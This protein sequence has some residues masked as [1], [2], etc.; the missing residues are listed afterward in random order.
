M[1]SPTVMR[2]AKRT[3]QGKPAAQ[4]SWLRRVQRELKRNHFAYIVMIPVL[5]HFVLFEFDDDVAINALAVGVI[6]RVK[7]QAFDSG[8]FGALEAKSF[9]I[10]RDNQSQFGFDLALFVAVNDGLQ[11]AAV[12]R[13]EDCEFLHKIFL[14]I[15]AIF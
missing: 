15:L 14:V 4:R 3:I 10:T 13:N 11:V 8:F 1:N 2:E 12:T 9:F 6:G 7:N 5:I